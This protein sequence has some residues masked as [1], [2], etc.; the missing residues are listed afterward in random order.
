MTLAH[1]NFPLSLLAWESGGKTRGVL[2]QVLTGPCI[3][4]KAIKDE[5]VDDGGNIAL[6]NIYF[7]FLF[8]RC[9]LIC[10]TIFYTRSIPR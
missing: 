9:V 2:P 4:Y 10:Y 5:Q 6:Q 8:G 3:D 1:E 7:V